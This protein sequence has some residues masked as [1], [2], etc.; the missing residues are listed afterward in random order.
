[1][2]FFRRWCGV[3]VAGAVITASFF[4][5]GCMVGAAAAGAV[6]F[7]IKCIFTFIFLSVIASARIA[8]FTSTRRGGMICGHF[9]G[10]WRP[11]RAGRLTSMVAAHRGRFILVAGRRRCLAARCWRNFLMN[12]GGFSI[13]LRWRNGRWRRIHGPLMRRRFRSC[14]TMA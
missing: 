14:G 11:R 7:F 6:V 5:F 12:S 13:F 2:L 4:S 10:R 1:M 3:G 8:A 9:S